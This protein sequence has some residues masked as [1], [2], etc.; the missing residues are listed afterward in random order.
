MVSKADTTY[1]SKNVSADRRAQSK[2]VHVN[3][4]AKIT[5]EHLKRIWKCI[6]ELAEG[7]FEEIQ[8]EVEVTN[9]FPEEFYEL[10][11]KNDLYRF[12]LPSEY[13]GWDLDERE[14]LRVQ[15]EASRGPA[16]C[17]CTCITLPT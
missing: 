11:K 5:D 12:Y 7:P 13:G 1:L 16:A 14:I 15:E 17:A 6:Q 4:N 9:T 8:K 2:E 3:P 10:A